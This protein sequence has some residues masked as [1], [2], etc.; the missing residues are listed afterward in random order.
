MS[1]LQ[2]L[3]PYQIGFFQSTSLNGNV[4]FEP[5]GILN[6]GIQKKLINR[7]RL[8]LNIS[9]LF[10]SL[11]RIEVTDLRNESINITRTF[12]FSQRTFKLTYSGTF[13]NQ[14]LQ[15]NR[16]RNSGVTEKKRVN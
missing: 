11:E 2:I 16:K 8:T 9:D 5:L 15:K 4:K 1:S 13:G 7:A 6:F 3:A 14:K 12:D 10:N